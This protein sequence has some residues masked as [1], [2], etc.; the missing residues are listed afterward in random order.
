MVGLRS[1]RGYVAS[2][3]MG[4]V[5]LLHESLVVGSGA[6]VQV[7]IVMR[8]DTAEV[9]GTIADAGTATANL[10]VA[11]K[12]SSGGFVYCV[13][14]PESPGRFETLWVSED[15]KFQS[16]LLAP[17]TYRM[18]AFK[19]SQINLPYRDPE[20]MNAYENKGQVVHLSAGEKATV[21]LQIVSSD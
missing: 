5:D 7:E 9:D 10:S 3:T 15:G 19:S 13:P 1:S 14:L 16:S 4:G 21:Q 11:A 2:A 8:D 12:R 18:L 17:G 20:A 6:N